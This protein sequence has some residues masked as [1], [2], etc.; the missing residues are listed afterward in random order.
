MSKFKPAFDLTG[1]IEECVSSVFT[2][3]WLAVVWVITVIFGGRLLALLEPV[4]SVVGF[5]GLFVGLATLVFWLLRS[6]ERVLFYWIE[7][8]RLRG[9]E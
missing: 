5:F 8:Q 2:L 6:A 3:F 4:A 1:A 7:V 9:G